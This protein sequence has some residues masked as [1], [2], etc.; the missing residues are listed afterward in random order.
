MTRTLTQWID[1][2]EGELARRGRAPRTRKSYRETLWK[3]ADANPE[4]EPG[5][6][7]RETCERF[8]DRWLDNE[9]A[10]MAQRAAALGGYPHGYARR[11]VVEEWRV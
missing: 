10:T 1:S 11:C 6:I 5:R 8:L 2:F 9:P 4:L 7:D 3:F